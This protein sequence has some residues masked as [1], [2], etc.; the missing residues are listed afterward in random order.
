ME[1]EAGRNYSMAEICTLLNYNE[2]TVTKK[3]KKLEI[4]PAGKI[5]NKRYFAAED[6]QRIKEYKPLPFNPK[7]EFYRVSVLVGNHWIVKSAGLTKKQ[8]DV[9]IKQ[10]ETDGYFARCKSC[11]N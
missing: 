10:F 4:K 7:T 5:G 2:K 6:V 11:K 1:I 3:I 9:R 8:A